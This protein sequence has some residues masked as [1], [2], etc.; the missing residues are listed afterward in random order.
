MFDSR[1][2]L[3]DCTFAQITEYLEFWKGYEEWLD[4]Q[5]ESAEYERMVEM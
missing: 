4:E 2:P 5:A 3:G 1:M